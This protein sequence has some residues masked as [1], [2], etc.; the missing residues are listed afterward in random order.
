VYDL[1]AIDAPTRH[2]PYERVPSLTRWSYQIHLNKLMSLVR[3]RAGC[4]VW[5]DEPEYM[6][7]RGA[8]GR[9]GCGFVSAIRYT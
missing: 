3:H 8:W 2:H 1:E 9:G 6:C 7:E 4:V 5:T